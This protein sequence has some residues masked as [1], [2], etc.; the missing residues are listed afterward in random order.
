[1]SEMDRRAYQRFL[2][3]LG[4]AVRPVEVAAAK[5]E[6]RVRENGDS[7]GVSFEWTPLPHGRV[8]L[9]IDGRPIMARIAR[10]T[11]DEYLIESQGRQ[12][13]LRAEDEVTARASK[14]AQSRTAASGPITILAP[15]PGTIVQIMVSEGEAVAQGQ[16]ILI[17]EA[18]KMQNEL[19]APMG[20]T[21][22]GLKASPGQAVEARQ[23]L[24]QIVPLAAR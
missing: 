1:M 14:N 6:Y 12:I 8:L 21:I 23:P 7:A 22:K 10:V 3:R 11:P 19:P 24:C 15:M 2:T 18:M 9:R 17:I 5:N 4:D 16:S 20:G 13:I